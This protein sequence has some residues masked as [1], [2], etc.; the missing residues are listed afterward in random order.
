MRVRGDLALISSWIKSNS[1][2]L[3]LGCGDGNLLK[4]L[5]KEKN[6]Q[7]YGV[8]SDITKIKSSLDNNINV[9]HLDLD[10]DLSQFDANSF[11]YVVLAQ[12]LQEIKRPKNLIKEMLRI[13][14]E[15]IVSFPNM[16][17]WSSRM[18]L[19]FKGMMPI[20]KNLPFKWDETPNIHLCTIKDFIEFCNENNFKIIK[21]LITDENQKHNILTKIFPNFF[22]KVAT[23]RIR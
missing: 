15:I 1:K 7:G 14:D 4:L 22:G 5:K 23:Y 21:Q 10:N 16:G 6:I 17:H 12:S 9:L 3:D 8:D 13:G 19:L 18:Q 11:D 2:V 20:T